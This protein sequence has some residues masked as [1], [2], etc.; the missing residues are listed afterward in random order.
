MQIISWIS[1]HMSYW[2]QAGAQEKIYKYYQ[3]MY[4]I[5]LYKYSVVNLFR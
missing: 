1:V 3:Y 5:Y 2:D 4:G